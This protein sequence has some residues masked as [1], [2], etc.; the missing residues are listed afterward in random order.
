MMA[1]GHVVLA[2]DSVPDKQASEKIVINDDFARKVFDEN[3]GGPGQ[4]STLK[5]L[6]SLD[7][8]QLT[9]LRDAFSND[10]KKEEWE[11]VFPTGSRGSYY[12][13]M[14]IVHTI[15]EMIEDLKYDAV[16]EGRFKEEMGMGP[17]TTFY[18]FK[19]TKGKPFVV[20]VTS[21]TL[22]PCDACDENYCDLIRIYVKN[23]VARYS[24]DGS[25]KGR[26]VVKVDVLKACPKK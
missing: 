21:G 17:G 19:P 14:W 11:I 8:K 16:F 26:E 24:P 25:K 7:R 15:E 10:F 2:Q 9:E 13:A 4:K 6:K 23:Y 18:K 3:C 20:L 12:C 5:I 1:F 22:F